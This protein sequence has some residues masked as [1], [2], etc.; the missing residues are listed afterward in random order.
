M[1]LNSFQQRFVMM[2]CTCL[3]LFNKDTKLDVQSIKKLLR[4]D[5]GLAESSVN[6]P[7]HQKSSSKSGRYRES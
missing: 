1:H 7:N 2:K 4:E 6:P 5:L 3:K